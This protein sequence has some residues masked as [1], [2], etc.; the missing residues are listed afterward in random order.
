MRQNVIVVRSLQPRAQ[1]ASS[2]LSKVDGLKNLLWTYVITADTGSLD[3]YV[4]L[5]CVSKGFS[6]QSS[7]AKRSS[8]DKIMHAN[9]V[10][11][12]TTN[13]RDL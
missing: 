2:K 6:I 9:I 7:D 5:F 4:W 8:M 11:V 13:V 10:N 3:T 12:S 1:F